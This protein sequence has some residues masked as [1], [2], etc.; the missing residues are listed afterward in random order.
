[1]ADILPG[2]NTTVFGELIWSSM[3]PAILSNFTF[4]LNIAKAV[5]VLFI[6]YLA[7]LIL[8]V[9]VQTRQA[10]RIKSIESHVTSID[11]KLDRLLQ[12]KK[13]SPHDKGKKEK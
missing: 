8:K 2:I 4:L 5:G 12:H 13:E 9:I 1:M 10:L 11:Q 7:F 6:I 3:P